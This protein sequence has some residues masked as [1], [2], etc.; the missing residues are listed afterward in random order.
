METVEETP[1]TEQ[2]DDQPSRLGRLASRVSTW[3]ASRVSSAET[4]AEQK[5]LVRLRERQEEKARRDA[6]SLTAV[7]KRR[8]ATARL[9]TDAETE[10]APVPDLMRKIGAWLDR[11]VGGAQLLAPL[12]VSGFFTVQVGMDHPLDM[13][14]GIALAFTL[15]LE[16]SLWY[17]N[18]LREQT[19]LEGDSTFSLTAA[20][21]GI[22]LLIAGLIGGHAI[23]KATGSVPIGIGLPGT[24]AEVPLS[25]VVPAFAVALM[26]AIG[27]FVWAKRATFQHRVKLRQQN[28][29]D[30][31]APKFAV[32]SWIFC[33]LET[34]WS[35]RH[36]IK[37]RLSSPI[38]AV[39]DWRL[40]KLSDKPK[41]WPALETVET[42]EAELVTETRPA[43]KLHSVPSETHQLSPVSNP[44][45]L[46][47]GP[48]TREETPGE[49]NGGDD[50]LLRK[51]AS[52]RSGTSPVSYGTIA[53]RLGISKAHA[54][55][56]GVAA[57][58]RGLIVSRDGGDARDDETPVALAT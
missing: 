12:V 38:V 34:V 22:I 45:P 4:A 16:G 33:P 50:R 6:A 40:W 25:D 26:S 7:T 44:R 24:E 39:E 58:N 47:A 56:L 23:W 42:L 29:I 18:R 11:S 3:K 1:V 14:L 28:R 48:E 36:A 13:G 19:R 8:A 49:T 57:K 54:G 30:P 52:L 55:R 10:I 20:I 32:A 9:E 2:G 51:V 5:R 41:V 27:T 15:G 17:L 35:L 53:S 43:R 37:Y 46:T 21:L 31:A